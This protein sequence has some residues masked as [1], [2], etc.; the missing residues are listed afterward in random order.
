MIVNWVDTNCAAMDMVENVQCPSETDVEQKF[1]GG[2]T[3][4]ARPPWSWSWSSWHLD[5]NTSVNLNPQVER[6]ILFLKEGL[7]KYLILVT[8]EL[9]YLWN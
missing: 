6:S 4:S 7:E 1:V 3:R 8:L 5:M 2:V 9:E